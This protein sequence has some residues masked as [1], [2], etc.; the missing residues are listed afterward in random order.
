[1][2]NTVLKLLKNW[3]S[4]CKQDYYILPNHP[5]L[6]CYGTGYGGWAVQTN[7]KAL[8]AL[9]MLA[10]ETKD[11]E[12]IEKALKMLRFSLESHI[13]GALTCLDGRKWGHTWISV[14]GIERMM[15]GV[16]ALMPYMTDADK[17][18]LK[19][20]LLSECDWLC[21][22]YDIKADLLSKDGCNRPESNV[23]NGA[24]LYRTAFMYPDAPRTAQY[25]EKAESY[26]LNGICLPQDKE[27]VGCT[28]S[29]FFE[30]YA[31][32]HHG[33][34]NVGY[35]VITL[36]QIAMLHFFC[37]EHQ[38]QPPKNLYRH[39][40]ELWQLVKSCTAPDGRLIRIGGD[41]RVRYCYCQDYAIPVWLFA[42]DYLKDSDCEQYISGWLKTVEKETAFNQN[43][44]FLSA[45]CGN[46]RSYSPIYYTRLE[47]D[48][49]A[50]LSM[51]LA[52]KPDKSAP[53]E[54]ITPLKT[55]YDAYHGSLF[56]QNEKNIRSWTWR[57]AGG[58]VG[59]CLPKSDT[60]LAEWDRN[61]VG[62]IAGIGVVHQYE[63]INHNETMFSN[64][65]STI[66]TLAIS[67]TLFEAE[68][69]T[70]DTLGT[71]K[72]A[73]SALPDG[74]TAIVLQ[75][76]VLPENARSYIQ[77]IKGLNLNVPND[78]FNDCT[79]QYF[80][81]KEAFAQKGLEKETAKSVGKWINI[82]N[83][84]GVCLLYGA[85]NF[86]LYSPGKRQIAI[87]KYAHRH[88]GFD[89]G[90]LYC[91]QILTEFCNQPQDLWGAQTVI[92]SGVMLI[93]GATGAETQKLSASAPIIQ[94]ICGS[95]TCIRHAEAVGQDGNRYLCL[96]NFGTQ[97]EHVVL[98]YQNPKLLDL[99]NE[100]MLAGNE[101]V[102]PEDSV[103]L[104][105]ILEK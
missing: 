53:A 56:V 54:P 32:N 4:Y 3:D 5:D 91:D 70:L 40:K 60:T 63:L 44:S 90:N 96:A 101:L 19:K 73:F 27:I 23:W 8:G 102:I 7:Q 36:S 37:K 41:T 22:C 13:E 84:L 94:M 55:W 58:P 74:A 9:A 18:L 35:M 25:I 20:V 62:E 105:Q 51:L 77:N 88:T 79:R 93:A 86:T 69:Q 43:G 39:V 21:D 82:D 31:L 47:S 100:T 65:F 64:G 48:R 66:G 67:G 16:D 14:L 103:F 98:N 104:F 83:R 17:E 2:Q 92:D 95:N 78:L 97:S 80:T 28:G 49:A 11:K 61:L 59:L 89:T 1:M 46:M 10:V 45:R 15:H 52:W 34:M 29:N 33:Y 50:A 81:E 87:H 75:H 24:V 76:A 85:E 42:I 26:F 12:L 30:S 72:I 71:E 6:L 99:H 38:I 68:Q 57:G